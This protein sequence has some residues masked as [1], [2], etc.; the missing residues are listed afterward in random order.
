M[1]TVVLSNPFA[2]SD[3]ITSHLFHDQNQQLSGQAPFIVTNWFQTYSQKS[4][5]MTFYLSV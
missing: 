4:T 3:Q 2:K 1:T 5:E